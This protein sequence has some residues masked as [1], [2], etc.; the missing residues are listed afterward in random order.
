M[1]ASLHTGRFCRV[2]FFVCLPFFGRI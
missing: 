2:R 1:I